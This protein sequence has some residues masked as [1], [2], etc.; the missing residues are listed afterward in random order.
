MSQDFLSALVSYWDANTALVAAGLT[1][2]SYGINTSFSYP[3][4]TLQVVGG[5]IGQRTF[6]GSYIE[7]DPYRFSIYSND[8]DQAAT[9][10]DVVTTELDK[11]GA[12]PLTF[13]NGRQVSFLRSGDSLVKT[14]R[15]GPGG[16]LFVWLQV[17]IYVA[18]ISRG[19]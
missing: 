15:A 17:V 16:E 1:P 4:V 18:K 14:R 19:G 9:L 5:K 13:Q 6:T 8:E 3:Y 11:I 2:I 12:T 10:G 7:N